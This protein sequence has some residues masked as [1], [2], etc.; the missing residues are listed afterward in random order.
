MAELLTTS[1]VARQL[2]VSQTTIWR[3]VKSGRLVAAN[4]L[5]SG[6]Y[7]FTQTAVDDCVAAVKIRPVAR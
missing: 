7:V 3:W 1:Q 6:A 2:D 5:A 4:Q